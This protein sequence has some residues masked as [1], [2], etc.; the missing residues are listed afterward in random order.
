MPS[1]GRHAGLLTGGTHPHVH[2]G[3]STRC[4]RFVRGTPDVGSR[5]PALT[6]SGREPAVRELPPHVRRHTS[7][8]RGDRSPAAPGTP[9]DARVTAPVRC[10][11]P[12]G[13]A[14]PRGTLPHALEHRP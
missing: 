8:P 4:D 14:H 1:S 11:V 10:A 6:G 3:V 2:G 9:S 5:V 12:G 7:F 13:G